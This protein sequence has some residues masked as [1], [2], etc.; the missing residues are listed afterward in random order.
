M[1]LICSKIKAVHGGQ[2]PQGVTIR[3]GSDGHTEAEAR[4]SRVSGCAIP[5]PGEPLKHPKKDRWHQT[6]EHKTPYVR[7]TDEMTGTAL[8]NVFTGLERR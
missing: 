4:R 3:V 8:G 5:T 1:K 2:G 6:A 7:N